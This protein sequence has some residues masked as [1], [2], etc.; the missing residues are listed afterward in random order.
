MTH[1]LGVAKR[2]VARL[3]VA[4]SL[5]PKELVL[6]FLVVLE[7]DGDVLVLG[8]VAGLVVGGLFIQSLLEEVS[9][10]SGASS[11]VEDFPGVD[12]S[13]AK[14]QAFAWSQRCQACGNAQEEEMQYMNT[15][16]LN[17]ST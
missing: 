12:G 9:R 11:R 1:K 17:S 13:R 8:G 6:L 14:V 2:A 4:G 7:V 10:K 5:C 3:S 15:E 16:H